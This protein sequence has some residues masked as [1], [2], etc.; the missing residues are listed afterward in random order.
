MRYPEE[1]TLKGKRKTG[2]IFCLSHENFLAKSFLTSS[3]EISVILG[4]HQAEK[5]TQIQERNRACREPITTVYMQKKK[6]LSL[7]I[8]CCKIPFV[9][10]LLLC[11]QDTAA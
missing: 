2:R 10:L 7:L 4:C 8:C 1:T 9:I 3:N 5:R 6:N 11:F